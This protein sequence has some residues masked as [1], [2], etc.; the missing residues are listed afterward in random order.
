MST[1]NPYGPYRS[2]VNQTSPQQ[3]TSQQVTSGAYRAPQAGLQKATVA[4]ALVTPEII[5][6]L[7][8]TAIWARIMS[9]F[10]IIG[11]V[12][13]ALYLV[14]MLFGMVAVLGGKAGIVA[15]VLVPTIGT[16]VASFY[17]FA[18]TNTLATQAK[19][20][21]TV[22]DEQSVALC[23]S[24]FGSYLKIQSILLISMFV[25]G[26]VAALAMPA[27]LHF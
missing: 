14:T 5:H 6:C 19:Y 4:G 22:S 1:E 10:C 20:L 12:L 24:S 8:T 18:R 15:I 7:N 23:L 27:A 9:I 21:N 13:S 16:M 11:A 3:T 2:H 25:F 26:I 17:L